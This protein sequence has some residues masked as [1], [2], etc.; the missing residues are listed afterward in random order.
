MKIHIFPFKR[1]KE[2]TEK[3]YKSLLN[4]KKKKKSLLKAFTLLI[5][6]MNFHIPPKK[7]KKA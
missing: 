3:N 2:V 5:I 7:R 4:Q 6:K 1:E